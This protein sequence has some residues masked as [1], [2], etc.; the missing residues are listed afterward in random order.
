MEPESSLPYSQAPINLLYFL[1]STWTKQ[2]KESRNFLLEH[3]VSLIFAVLQH[4]TVG[5]ICN[6]IVRVLVKFIYICSPYNRPL[7][8]RGWVEV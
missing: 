2:L 4:T 6:K 7:K 5:N 8:P 3:V 1:T